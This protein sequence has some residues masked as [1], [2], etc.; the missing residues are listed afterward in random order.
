MLENNRKQIQLN[1]A[2]LETFSTQAT[3][4]ENKEAIENKELFISKRDKY[5]QAK[6]VFRKNRRNVNK[7]QEFYIEKGS[8]H[9]RSLAMKIKSDN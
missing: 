2:M 4:E 7:L 1:D 5:A 6:F 8:T 9:K 3:Y